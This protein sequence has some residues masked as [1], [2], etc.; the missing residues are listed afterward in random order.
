MYDPQVVD[1]FFALHG[2]TT[3][4]APA[5]IGEQRPS[6]IQAPLR[7]GEH[8]DARDYHTFFD[9]GQALGASASIHDLG[10][11][12]WTHFQ[13]RL[14]ASTCVLYIY[15]HADDSLVSVYEPPIDACRVGASRIP[16]GERVSGWVAAT[17]QTAV[18][19]DARLDL[20]DDDRDCSPLRSALAARLA[21][22]GR[23]IGVITFYAR[24]PNAFDDAHRQLLE[25]ASSVFARSVAAAS[26]EGSRHPRREAQNSTRVLQN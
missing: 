26:D 8:D 18:N 6:A 21:S 12:I 7:S 4:S 14:S 1:A 15:N 19:S 16:L 22:N 13:P 23:T 2:F 17:G 24:D 10:D 3:A 5:V 9:A 11:V 20:D 25:A